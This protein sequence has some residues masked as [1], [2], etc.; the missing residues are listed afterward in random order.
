[1]AFPCAIH[2]A[3]VH[4]FLVRRT[5]LFHWLKSPPHSRLTHLLNVADCASWISRCLWVAKDTLNLDNRSPFC[6]ESRIWESTFTHVSYR[7]SNRLPKSR[8][9]GSGAQSSS[10][11][12]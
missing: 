12:M 3:D 2:L 9:S 11:M 10:L 6:T 1:M 4:S 8:A 5:A 7:G